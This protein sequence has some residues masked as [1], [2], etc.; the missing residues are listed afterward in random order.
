MLKKIYSP[1]RI[2]YLILVTLSF[3]IN[4]Y[5]SN[6]G[7]LPQDTFAYY[8]TGYRVLNGAI[9]FK[10]YWTVSGP[11]IDFLQAILFSIF[12]VS[13]EA[14]IINGSI[15][16]SLITVIF[17][18]TLNIYNQRKSLNLFYCICFSILANP[19]LHIMDS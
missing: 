4:F 16:N 9:P 17:Y 12:S 7:V 8:D 6:L 13:W 19:S 14:Y 15:I 18:Y 10:D 11:F 3:F 5:Y 1:N 2:N